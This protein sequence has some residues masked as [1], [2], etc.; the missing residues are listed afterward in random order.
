[1]SHH[2]R[3]QQSDSK[4]R[5]SKKTYARN[6]AAKALS[7]DQ[8]T[9]LV[10]YAKAAFEV[11]C[12][13][14]LCESDETKFRHEQVAIATGKSGIRECNNSHFRSIAAHF[15]RLAGREKEADEIWQ[16]TGRVKGSD[17][18]GDTHENRENAKAILRDLVKL[19]CGEIND[20]YVAHI[21]A[22]QCR[23][24]F[25]EKGLDGLRASQLQSVVFVVTQRLRQK[26]PHLAL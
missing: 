5:F 11:Q 1:M 3:Q 22:D 18:V 8:K 7:N 9:K 10:M 20:E 19:S 26:C 2:D 6:W 23:E 13:A 25:R 15:L 16:K 24:D 14:G 4:P 21:A 12:R 17:E